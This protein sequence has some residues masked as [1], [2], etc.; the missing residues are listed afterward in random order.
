M[1]GPFPRTNP[2][3]ARTGGTVTPVRGSGK[4]G[5]GMDK[6]VPSPADAVAD[7]PDGASLAVGGFGLSG[8]PMNLIGRLHDRG[9]SDLK[10]VSNNCGVDDWGLGILLADRRIARMTSS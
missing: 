2:D 4:R 10:V 8:N 3:R 7:I 6:V 5:P 1:S 9:T